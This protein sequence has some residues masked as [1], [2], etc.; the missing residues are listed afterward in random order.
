MQVEEDI[1]AAGAQLIWVLEQVG[2]VYWTREIIA[3]RRI[4]FAEQDALLDEVFKT[5]R[6]LRCCMDQTGMGE[7][8]VE[9][10]QRRYGTTRVEGVLF[11]GPNK[12]T[13]ATQGKEAFEDKRIRIPLGDRDLRADL[14]KLKKITSPTGTPRFV[15]DS[16]ADG[17]A[18]RAWACFM[19]L[20]AAGNGSVKIEYQGV[21]KRTDENYNGR[22]AW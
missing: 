11:T 13:M 2:D 16:D 3:R 22:R 9:D 18:D 14:H 17:H 6:V 4:S 19:A 15:A 10:A 12:L 5:Y 7:K 21:P 8:P 20:N 1:I